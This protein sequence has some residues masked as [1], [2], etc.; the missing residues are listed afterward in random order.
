MITDIKKFEI[1]NLHV[2]LHAIIEESGKQSLYEAQ[3]DCHDTKQFD[4]L[5]ELPY[6]EESFRY[7]ENLN[8]NWIPIE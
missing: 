6:C 4:E 2:T 3:F 1:Y 8:L 7:L 5:V